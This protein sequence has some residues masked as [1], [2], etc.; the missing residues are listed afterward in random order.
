MNLKKS[1]GTVLELSACFR[2]V[3]QNLAL[4]LAFHTLSATLA[5]LRLKDETEKK[6]KEDPFLHDLLNLLRSFSLIFR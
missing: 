5:T 1:E 4:P 3:M 6:K 2:N